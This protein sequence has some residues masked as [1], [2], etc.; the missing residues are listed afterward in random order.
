MATIYDLDIMI[1]AAAQLNM[2]KNR[3][4][5]N[6]ARTLHTRT[7]DLLRAIGRPAGGDHVKAVMAGIG[8]LQSTVIKT[9]IRMKDGDAPYQFSWIDSG[10]G[11]R[12]RSLTAPIMNPPPYR[13]PSPTGFMNGSWKTAEF[14]PSIPIISPSRAAANVG[15]IGLSASMPEGPGLPVYR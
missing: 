2:Q 14:F 6:P 3:G 8:R 1:W 7:Y 12:K 4:I 11:L 13:S 9:N 5:Q 10:G 15:F